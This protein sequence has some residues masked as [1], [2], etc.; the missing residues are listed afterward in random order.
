MAHIVTPTILV[1]S[2]KSAVVHLYI[3][4]DGLSNDLVNQIIVDP[5]LD[6]VDSPL[7]VQM[8]ITQ[9]WYSFGWFDAMLSFDDIT[10]LESA[11]IPSTPSWLLTRDTI[12]YH[13]FR[14]FGGIKDKSTIDGTGRIVLTTNG[15]TTPG[16]KGTM[17]LEIRKNKQ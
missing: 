4:S 9:V 2:T 12:G 1:D 17:V 7:K 10:L 14:Y 6:F 11:G 13:D 3:E 15:L 16:S 8:A 5:T